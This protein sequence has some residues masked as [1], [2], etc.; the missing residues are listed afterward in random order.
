MNPFDTNRIY[1]TQTEPDLL[2]CEVCMKEIP[3]SESGS[4]EAT[5]YVIYFFGIEC[6]GFWLNKR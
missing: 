1:E 5:D 4:S 6:F 3:I 2:S